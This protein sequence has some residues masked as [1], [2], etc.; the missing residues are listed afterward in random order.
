VLLAAPLALFALARDVPPLPAAWYVPLHAALELSVI[1][2]AFAAFA[3]QWYAAGALGIG[4]A[5]SIGPAMLVAAA[6]EALHLATFPGMP[7]LAGPA[8]T[9][10]A[11]YYW[12][13]ARAWTVGA[14]LWIARPRARRDA[15]S[16]RR[17]ANLVLQLAAFVALVAFELALP[18]E[19]A[20]FFVEGRGLTPLKVGVELAIGVAAAAGAALHWRAYRLSG[21]RAARRIALALL[22]A[23]LCSA[24]LSLYRHPY[25]PIHVLGHVYLVVAF[26]FVFEALFVAGVARPYRELEA[27][28][29]HVQNELVVTIA[30]LERTQAEREDLLRAVTHDL[31]NPLQVVLLQSQRLER[32]EDRDAAARAAR[33]VRAAG[34]RM[35][36]LI[37]DLADTASLE[38]GAALPL[39]RRPVALRPFV[40]HLLEHADGVLDA[41]RVTNAVPEALPPLDADP[42]RLDRILVNLVGNALKYTEGDVT[43][44]AVREDA[45]VRVLVRDRGAGLTTEQRARLFERWYRAGARDREGLGLGL[46]IVRGLVEA[47]G[48]RVAVESVP[49]EGS[50]FSFTFPVASDATP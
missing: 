29:S 15:P 23:A 33:T 47:H 2:V 12:L 43:I 17:E 41:G 34:R 13:L 11:I 36:R 19:R 40:A 20:I 39:E 28:R 22:A 45:A 49:G 1:S 14:L 9:E 24:S 6:F 50:T 37:R 31:R 5:R 38:S 42:D 32:I 18:R 25:D 21:A 44:A 16:L 10:R 30:R 26:G 35:E 48:G 4:A 8:S 27:L 7:G 3:V 46:H